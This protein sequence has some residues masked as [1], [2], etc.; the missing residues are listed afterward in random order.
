VDGLVKLRTAEWNAY[1]G[2]LTQ[3]ERE[4]TLDC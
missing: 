3:W 2:H 4:T 1:A